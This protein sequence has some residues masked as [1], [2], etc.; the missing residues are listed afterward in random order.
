MFLDNSNKQVGAK[1][2]L[3]EELDRWK[4]N[5]ELTAK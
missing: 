4:V 2:I 1:S 5:D 3:R